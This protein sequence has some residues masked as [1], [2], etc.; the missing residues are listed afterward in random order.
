MKTK[1]EILEQLYMS[2]RDLKILIPTMGM[3]NCI[4]TI[5]EVREEMEIKKIFVPQSKP[6]LAL[7]KLVKRKFGI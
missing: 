7:T 6:L 1:E 5:K 3:Q 2:P 4:K